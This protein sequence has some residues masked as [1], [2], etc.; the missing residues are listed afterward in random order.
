MRT[1]FSFIFLATS[2][3]ATNALGALPDKFYKVSEGI[4]RSA[5]PTASDYQD[6]KR[7]GIKTV[8][9]LNNDQRTLAAETR[10]AGNLGIKLIARPMSAFSTPRDSD[11][12][13][14]LEDL[15]NPDNYPILIH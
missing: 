2:C 9:T 8:L 11:V 5:Q 15:H 13:A 1:F 4:Y 10:T 7:M 12:N 14:D 3:F 6:L